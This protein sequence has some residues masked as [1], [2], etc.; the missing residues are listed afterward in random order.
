MGISVRCQPRRESLAQESRRC[1]LSFGGCGGLP[2]VHSSALLP[3]NL[4]ALP[5][6]HRNSNCASDRRA[7]AHLCNP[8]EPAL[9]CVH[10]AQRPRPVSRIPLVL[11]H[12]RTTTPLPQPALSARLQYRPTDLVL[13]LP[14]RVALSLQRV[15]PG[16]REAFL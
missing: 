7:L 6:A 4:E 10:D 12:Q 5:S 13:A 16:S 3:A 1:C 14:P 2:R 11:F 9:L 15:P 8:Q